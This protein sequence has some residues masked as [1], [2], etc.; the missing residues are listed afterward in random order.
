[1]TFDIWW[2]VAIG[3]IALLA[4]TVG[5]IAAVMTS[6]QK[7]LITKKRQLEELTISEHKY[8]NLFEHSPAGML[9]FTTDQWVVVDANHALL[10]MFAVQTL[11]EVK[12]VLTSMFPQDRKY[13]VER[14]STGQSVEDYK[15]L[16]CRRDGTE[17]WIS[18]SASIH[19]LKSITEAVV[20]DITERRK[21]EDTIREQAMLLD[22]AQVGILVLD[23]H[24]NIRYWN[25]GAEHMFGYAPLEVVGRDVVKYLFGS[26][27]SENFERAYKL[28]LQHSRWSGELQ[29]MKRDGTMIVT[30]CRWT[31]VRN[32]RGEP[33]GILQVCT[34]ITER[35]R[36]E[37]SFLKAQ[38]V[39]SIGI[40]ASGIAHDIRNT[41]APVLLG[42]DVLKR[43]LMDSQSR[44]LLKAIEM[45]AKHGS[46]MV[47]QVLSF[48]KGVEGKHVKLNPLKIMKDMTELLNHIVPGKI[49]VVTHISNTVSPV[50]GD[51][52]QLHQVLI[53]LCTNARDAMP[54]GGKLAFS[55]EN[56][57]VTKEL[58]KKHPD[59]MEG[60]FVVF[61]ISDTGVG[62][63]E[64]DLLKIFEP[65]YT[66]KE[67]G[68]GTGLGLSISL[69]IVKGHK[70]FMTV[71]SAEG[72]GT[73]FKLFLPVASAG[74][75]ETQEEFQQEYHRQVM[76]VASSQEKCSQ[77]LL[78]G[79]EDSG[80]EPVLVIGKSQIT[81][82]FLQ[83]K[84][85]IRV[86]VLEGFYIH[87]ISNMVKTIEELEP[88]SRIVV[89]ADKYY[90][91]EL[92]G[93]DPKWP[94][95]VLILPVTIESLLEKIEQFTFLR[96]ESV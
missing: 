31:L 21:A 20:I 92:T 18:F 85:K 8:R 95:A 39:E 13:L 1:M 72:K 86:I 57:L 67:F 43:K 4:I 55:V 35:K 25:K 78:D 76:Y 73:T 26:I 47:Y 87:E 65:F 50:L 63:P 90:L 29:Q 3:T 59:A 45:S 69:G 12:E 23:L 40:F 75:G 82:A 70:G 74:K 58:T 32:P 96:K 80:Y 64:K 60:S 83:Q 37:M 53:N 2:T 16:L 6:K 36:L 77:A 41:L 56:I 79:L 52:T 48:V 91:D 93:G 38:R 15:T 89:L 30:D 14:L 22:Q 10:H 71:E 19:S 81:K 24:R 66:T 68:K 94:H 11:D 84:E 5:L 54:Q 51:A 49:D 27:E 62:V 46:E 88:E 44:R 28:T 33:A 61:S 34:D 7:E 17:F 42:I 9:R